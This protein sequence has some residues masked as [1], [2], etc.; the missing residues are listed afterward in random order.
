MFAMQG[1][2]KFVPNFCKKI[3][4]LRLIAD[5]VAARPLVVFDTVA[6]QSDFHQSWRRQRFSD[7]YKRRES[8][9]SQR[10]HE[11]F[12]GSLTLVQK[13]FLPVSGVP[14]VI[15]ADG[16]EGD[17][18]LAKLAV[19]HAAA[20]SMRRQTAEQKKMLAATSTAEKKKLAL[21]ANVVQERQRPQRTTT[22]RADEHL[23][24]EALAGGDAPPSATP[25]VVFTTDKDML[26]LMPFGVEIVNPF[27]LVVT[28]A[29]DVLQKFGVPPDRIGEA[30]AVGGD[31]CDGVKGVRGLGPCALRQ[32]FHALPRETSLAEALHELAEAVELRRRTEI[33]GGADV[34]ERTPPAAGASEVEESKNKLHNKAFKT[35]TIPEKYHEALVA[36]REKILFNYELTRLPPPKRFIPASLSRLNLPKIFQTADRK[37]DRSLAAAFGLQYKSYPTKMCGGLGVNKRA[38]FFLCEDIEELYRSNQEYARFVRLLGGWKLP[39]RKKAEKERLLRNMRSKRDSY[40]RIGGSPSSSSSSCVGRGTETETAG[41][42]VVENEVRRTVDEDVRVENEAVSRPKRSRKTTVSAGART[43]NIC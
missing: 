7:E 23:P 11:V 5:T 31:A 29:A 24:E 20:Q 15:A 8:W 2:E 28:R 43:A 9:K 14:F 22:R 6:G 40:L 30:L 17:D 27:D 33:C 16:M 10:E 36:N 38:P 41:V 26:Q 35:S 3:H 25:T 34:E 19:E 4:A 32:I 42:A 21:G 18:V 12:A 13:K 39:R 37:R 1:G